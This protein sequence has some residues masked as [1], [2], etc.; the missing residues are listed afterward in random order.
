VDEIMIFDNSEVKHELIAE[1]TIGSEMDI[2]NP[3]KFN[4]L[5][6]YSHENL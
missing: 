5:K 1:K 4:K 3:E 6:K 2:L